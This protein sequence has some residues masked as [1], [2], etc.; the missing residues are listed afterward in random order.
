MNNQ[1]FMLNFTVEPVMSD[2]VVAENRSYKDFEKKLK[3]K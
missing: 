3:C 2:D 1:I